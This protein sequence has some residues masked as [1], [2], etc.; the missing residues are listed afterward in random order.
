[1]PTRVARHSAKPLI[2]STT[3]GRP[4][5][6]KMEC[7][8]L[9]QRY[10][11]SRLMKEFVVSTVWMHPLCHLL[12]VALSKRVE[13]VHDDVIHPSPSSLPKFSAQRR[14]EGRIFCAE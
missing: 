7:G 12:D 11:I 5:D 1:M 4:W 2:K 8:P 9:D 14:G 10:Q 3:E 6:V 13:N